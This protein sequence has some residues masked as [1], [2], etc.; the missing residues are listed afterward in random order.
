MHTR[1]KS[2]HLSPVRHVSAPQDVDDGCYVSPRC[3]DCPLAVCLIDD[4]RHWEPHEDAIIRAF[5]NAEHAVKHLPFRS[6]EKVRKRL[7]YLRSRPTF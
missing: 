4:M 2:K 1:D 7:G 3:L 6:V 5:A